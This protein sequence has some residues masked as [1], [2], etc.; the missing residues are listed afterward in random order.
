M[1]RRLSPLVLLVVLLAAVPALTQEPRFTI[2]VPENNSLLMRARVGETAKR[3]IIVKRLTK[4][5]EVL[6]LSV[7]DAP[8][9]LEEDNIR[10]GNS[11]TAQIE[12]TFEPSRPGRFVDTVRMTDGKH[13][14]SVT[15]FGE[16]EPPERRWELLNDTLDFGILEPDQSEEARFGLKN[17][18]TEP[19]VLRWNVPRP[20][21]TT[22]RPNTGPVEPV[23]EI[24]LNPGET[25]YVLTIAHGDRALPGPNRDT[26]EISDGKP[27]NKD[28]AIAQQLVLKAWLG[29]T[30]GTR[31]G[32][33]V[34]IPA[35]LEFPIDPPQGGSTTTRRAKLMYSGKGHARVGQFNIIGMNA[36]NFT[37]TTSPLPKDLYPGD[38][39]V[40]TVTYDHKAVTFARA[41]LTVRGVIFDGTE[42]IDGAG[43]ILFAG[44]TNR[45]RQVDLTM[46]ATDAYVGGTSTVTFTN[47]GPIPQD[48]SYG[49]LSLRYNAT[50]LAPL[51]TTLDA[52]DP[53]EE[54]LRSSRFRIAVGSYD[55]GGV[56]G[57]VSFRVAL[58]NAA[59]TD[60][61][62]VGVQWLATDD[63]PLNVNSS[64]N[65]ATVNVLDAKGN[66]VNIDVGP[67]SL[68]VDPVPVIDQ[69][70]VTYSRGELPATLKMY[71]QMGSMVMDLTSQLQGASGSFT[72][73]GSAL[74]P[75]VYFLHLSGGRYSYVIR[76]LVE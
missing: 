64:I 8:F 55:E 35:A 75:A 61:D 60:V 9:F 39:V 51:S 36:R 25:A 42:R 20:V 37:F 54:G 14:A 70:T 34:F 50:V 46:S 76:M 41:V 26:L 43:M 66:E 12:V 2:L 69:A 22:H 1:L 48:V 28:G 58:G 16:A 65:S 32:R 29:D 18:D 15:L 31:P 6:K 73:S 71:D 33:L 57:S 27:F 40:V 59:S 17:N 7:P 23:T 38:S 21:F 30:T 74:P 68:T 62:V 53:I 44:D 5:L 63:T 45:A 56:F 24:R 3:L 4:Q 67:L 52:N 49:I 11:D 10:F 19:I 72:I 47:N 13:R